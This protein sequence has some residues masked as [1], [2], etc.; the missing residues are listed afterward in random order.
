MLYACESHATAEKFSEIEL[1]AWLK[2]NSIDR[3]P[4]RRAGLCV[5]ETCAL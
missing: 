1:S 2:E 4:V 3:L 5:R